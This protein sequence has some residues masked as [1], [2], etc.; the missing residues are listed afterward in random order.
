MTR[1]ITT[2]GGRNALPILSNK[3]RLLIIDDSAVTREVIRRALEP[4]GWSV[5]EATTGEA[6]VQLAITGSFDVILLDY[7]LPDTDG[8][9]VLHRLKSSNI[10]AFVVAIT[11]Y[12]NENVA[13]TFMKRGAADYVPKQAFSGLRILQTVTTAKRARDAWAAAAQSIST[14]AGPLPRLPMAGGAK[15]IRVLV[16]DD[17]AV[18]RSVYRRALTEQGWGVDEGVDGASGIEKALRGDYDV[19]LLDYHLPDSDGVQVIESLRKSGVETPVIAITGSGSDEVAARFLK[20]GAADYIR[21]A[22]A[23]PLRLTTTIRTVTWMSPGFDSARSK[24][25]EDIFAGGR[26][27]R[28]QQNHI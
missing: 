17:T 13:R 26:S 7:I 18:A 3:S 21:K 6:G 10:S 12:G 4:N 24:A 19:I 9:A 27:L 5:S 25:L 23:S 16:I 22:D 8:L 20:A 1:L 2:D 15:P 28:P 14:Q 11:S